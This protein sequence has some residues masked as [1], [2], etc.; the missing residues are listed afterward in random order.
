MLL[1]GA[2]NLR[3]GL[4]FNFTE[5]T[6]L[7]AL[8]TSDPTLHS[9]V[10]GGFNA[11][12]LIWQNLFYDDVVINVT[13]NY[14]PLGPGVLGSTGSAVYVGSYDEIRNA[15]LFDAQTVGDVVSSTSLPNGMSLSIRTN[16][17]SGAVVLD[18]DGSANNSNIVITGANAKA[19]NLITPGDSFYDLEDASLTFSSL[20]NFDFDRSDGIAG[21]AYDFIG[22]AAH[23][24]GHALGFVSGVDDVDYLSG[25][26]PGASN[27]LNGSDPGIGEFDDYAVFKV[28]DLFRN[29][30]LAE[31]GG[32]DYDWTTGGSPMFTIDGGTT[33][34]LPFSNGSFNGSDLRQA[35]HWKDNL[36]IGIM[37][38]TLGLG[39]EIN[40]TLFDLTAFDVIGWDLH[41]VPEPGSLTLCSLAVAGW[42]GARRRRST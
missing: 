39:E 24:I 6:E 25:V 8:A 12:G 37:D 28:L 22:T 7:A 35:S 20:F 21:S 2:S 9:Q 32:Y 3:A 33:L 29:S 41:A 1:G 23:E 17:R 31:S 16:D 34:L 5:G 18:N 30:S 10:I 42:Y 13:I 4:T 11:A 36:G 27:D 40:P 14:A 19:L 15:L 38:P 26:G